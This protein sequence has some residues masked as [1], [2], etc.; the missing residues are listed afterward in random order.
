MAGGVAKGHYSMCPPSN[1]ATPSSPVKQM[2][3]KEK[4]GDK[5]RS[6]DCRKCGDQVWVYVR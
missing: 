3:K 1:M 5:K 2:E 4:K 6:K